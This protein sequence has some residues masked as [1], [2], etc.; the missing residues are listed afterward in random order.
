MGDKYEDYPDDE[1]TIDINNVDVLVEAAK[2]IREGG[3]TL[4]KAGE[5]QEALTQYR[6]ESFS[7][8]FSLS[9]FRF[10]LLSPQLNGHATNACD[11]RLL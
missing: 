9:V 7:F 10:R 3:N 8:S 6:S 4:F 11:H 1:D 2:E 5:F